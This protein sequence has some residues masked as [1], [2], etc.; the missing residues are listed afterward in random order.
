MN[1][2][3]GGMDVLAELVTKLDADVGF[4]GCFVPREPRVPARSDP[5]S[6]MPA[7]DAAAKDD[8]IGHESE[9]PDREADSDVSSSASSGEPEQAGT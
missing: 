8:E 9:Q 1:V 3:A 2:E 4:I 7:G 5:S 6:G